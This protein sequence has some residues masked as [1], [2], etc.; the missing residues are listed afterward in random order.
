MRIAFLVKQLQT[1]LLFLITA[2]L[3]L[4]LLYPA[5]VTFILQTCCHEHANGSLVQYNGQTIGSSLIG[6]QFSANH[7]FWSRP[8]STLPLP[9]DPSE[10]EGSNLGANNALLIANINKY[11]NEIK[12]ADPTN[13][14]PVPVDLVTS[15][16]SGLD[17]HISIASAYFQVNRV[18]HARKLD[19]N[20]LNALINQHTTARTLG[21]L[22]EP[23]VN[24]LKLN[25]ALDA[26]QG[27]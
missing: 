23:C 15:S 13:P 5:V 11:V 8:S 16:G 18:A 22:G 6:Q 9:Y 27:E 21:F 25:L 1:T 2:L 3:V 20:T 14:F 17:P 12:L 10:S 4:G 19:P 26:L 7:Y 24:V